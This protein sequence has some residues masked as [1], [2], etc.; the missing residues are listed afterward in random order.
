MSRIR[1]LLSV[2]AMCWSLVLPFMCVK[3]YGQSSA[4]AAQKLPLNATLVLTPEFCGTKTKKG[5]WGV[6]QEAF[7]VGKA[8]CKELEPALKGVFNNVTRVEAAPSSGDGQLTLLPRFVDVSATQAKIAF[9]NRELVVLVEW[10][11]KD[12]AGKTVWLE[13]VQGSSKRHIGNMFT[14][15]KNLNHIV[16]DSVK[17]MAEQSATK[18]ASAPELQAES[19]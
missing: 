1:H 7:P 10:T 18:M 17:D 14:Y 16:E 9:S 4:P 6:N 19:N 12:K 15:K 8:A 3:M 2:S 13:T 11:V 5:T